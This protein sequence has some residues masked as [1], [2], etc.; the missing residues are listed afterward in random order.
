MMK[1]AI[2]STQTL[3]VAWYDKNGGDKMSQGEYEFLMLRF[4]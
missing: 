1:Y 2:K 3:L 4:K